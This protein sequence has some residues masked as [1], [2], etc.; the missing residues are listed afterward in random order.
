MPA[1]RFDL[2]A[3]YA[4]L[5]SKI[6]EVIANVHDQGISTDLAYMAWDSRGDVTELP[7]TDLIGIADWTWDEGDDHLPDIE[8]GILL[9]VVRDKNLFR[10]VAIMNEVRKVCVS[11]TRAKPEYKVWTVRDEANEPFAQLQVTS[12]S[13]MPSGESEART[14]RVI[15]ISLKRAD[16]GR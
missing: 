15:G 10:E 7:N 11:D 5:V 1:N 14:T 13:T 3:V 9:S 6:Q 16:Y 8:F 4:A 12:F 2:P